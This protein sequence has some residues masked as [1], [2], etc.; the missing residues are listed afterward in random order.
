MKNR[1]ALLLKLTTLWGSIFEPFWTHFGPLGTLLGGLGRP[2]WALEGPKRVPKWTPKR[3]KIEIF[4]FF[5]YFC[6]S[7]PK[8]EALLNVNHPLGTHFGRPRP[9]KRVPKWV[10][11]G[12][13]IETKR[14][15]NFNKIFHRFF[16]DFLIKN[17]S[18]HQCFSDDCLMIIDM[19]WILKNSE[20]KQFPH[21]KI[22]IFKGWCYLEVI[23]N[24]QK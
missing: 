4:W 23:K 1:W 8:K 3:S 20:K 2:R 15:V 24:Q 11:N 13:K 18:K 10:Q 19:C 16:I 22:D 5:G 12:S 6:Y 14:V 9:P 21:E 17:W 7:T